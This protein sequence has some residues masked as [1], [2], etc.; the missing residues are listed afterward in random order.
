MTPSLRELQRRFAATL[1][2]G[3]DAGFGVYRNTVQ[4][5]YRNAMAATYRV[6]RE[7]TGSAFFD[8][9]VDAFVAAH[10]STGG[11]LNVYGAEFASFLAS[12]P[13]G[14]DVPYLP[15]VARL[16]WA[17][18]DAS[19]AADSRDARESTL[20]ALGALT[21]DQLA[22]QRFNLE[23]SCRLI[24]SEFPVMSIWQA[25]QEQGDFDVDF[26]AGADHLLVRRERTSPVIERLSAAEHAW[27]VSLS[28]GDDLATAIGRAYAID[29]RFDLGATLATHIANGV[30][31]AA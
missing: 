1:D 9:A 12:Y 25:H 20:A 10:P 6:I 2:A 18:D 3:D 28:E 29:E 7:L 24:H 31:T 27:L 30:L 8:A 14:R 11:D 17:L 26:D 22:Q 4:A 19:R 13:H 5:N 15:D 21:G 23:A 16:E